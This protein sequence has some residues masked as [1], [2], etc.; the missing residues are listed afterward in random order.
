MF[1]VK[2]FKGI[3]NLIVRSEQLSVDPF[4][5]GAGDPLDRPARLCRA[6]YSRQP[7]GAADLHYAGFDDQ[8]GAGA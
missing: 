3:P 5:W 2:N 4:E 8:G 7:R 1:G 6:L